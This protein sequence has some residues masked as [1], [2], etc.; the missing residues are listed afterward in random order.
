MELMSLLVRDT[1]PRLV[2]ATLG[3]QGPEQHLL[4][5]WRERISEKRL[6]AETWLGGDAGALLKTC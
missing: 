5:T 1:L 3:S 2:D 4:T 6:E